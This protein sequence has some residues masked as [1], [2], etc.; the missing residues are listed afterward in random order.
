MRQLFIF[1]LH[2]FI[3]GLTAKA[4][5]ADSIA[6]PPLPVPEL[7]LTLDTSILHVDTVVANTLHPAERPLL[8][9]YD[10]PR[11][12]KSLDFS[13]PDWK[14]M[15]INGAVLTG[16]FV[17]TLFVLE[18]L[19]D[20][21]TNWNR[22]YYQKTPP[23]KR[24]HEYVCVKGPEWDSDSPIFNSLL[25]PYAGAVYFMSARSCGFSFWGSL[26]FST[27]ISNVMWEFGIEACMERPSYQ[28]LFIT[29]LI[30]S[31]VGEGFFR[32][33]R[34]LVANDYRLLGSPVLGNVVA[35]IV[36]PVN[37]VIGLFGG[38]PARQAAKRHKRQIVS[39]PYFTPRGGGLTVSIRF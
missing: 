14:R 34:Y 11:Q 32:I 24:W 3:I 21:A 10:F 23:W 8:S 26:I 31:V 18:L 35:F 37:E 27:V 28:D 7:D 22:A 29:P 6:R 5:T 15:W 12:N 9:I 38:N 39:S 4:Q 33:K 19:P 25:H 17:T 30:G 36:D 2:L 1:I 20:D 16:C 13:H